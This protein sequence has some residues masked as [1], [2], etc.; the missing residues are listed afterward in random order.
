M[1]VTLQ[2]DNVLI[3]STVHAAGD[4]AEVDVETA[5]RLAAEGA[6]DGYAIAGYDPCHR[7]EPLVEGA[8]TLR[9]EVRAAAGYFHGRR[10]EKGEVLELRE[11]IARE[12]TSQGVLAPTQRFQLIPKEA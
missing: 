3:G 6:V 9:V 12:M 2:R 8:P 1:K 5:E 11:D 10:Y 7:P 4:E